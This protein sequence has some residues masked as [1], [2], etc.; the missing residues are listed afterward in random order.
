MGSTLKLKVDLGFFIHATRGATLISDGTHGGI[1]SDYQ[2]YW[3]SIKQTIK[4]APST[5]YESAVGMFYLDD[6]P[7][8]NFESYGFFGGP[9]YGFSHADIYQMLDIVATMIKADF[10]NIPVV[11]V[12]GEPSAYRGVTYPPSIDWVGF[13]YYGC[14]TGG[15]GCETDFATLKNVMKSNLQ[16]NQQLLFVP[17]GYVVHNYYTG[18]TAT[19]Q[20]EQDYLI[21]KADFYVNAALSEPRAVGLLVF[22]SQYLVGYNA[23]NQPVNEGIGTWYI[24]AVMSKWRFLMRALGFGTP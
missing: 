3:A 16:T 22:E 7:Y 9:T 1:R 8:W 17:Y 10:P 18:S 21:G 23:L 11:V 24:P 6:E 5:S 12:E 2:A 4:P 14:E 20:A 19:T 13:D 15:G